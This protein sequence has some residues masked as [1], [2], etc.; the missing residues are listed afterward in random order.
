VNALFADNHV[1]P[2][3]TDNYQRVVVA[4]GGGSSPGGGPDPTDPLAAA[5][6]R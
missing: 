2:V 4:P 1:G 3:K 5:P 6:T